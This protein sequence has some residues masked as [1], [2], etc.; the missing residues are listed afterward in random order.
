M[1]FLDN[2]DDSARFGWLGDDAGDP[3]RDQVRLGLTALLTL[4]G[5]PCIYYG[6][7]QSLQGHAPPDVNDSS[8]YVREALWGKPQDPFDPT[9]QMAQLL[10]ALTRIRSSEPALRYGRQYFRQ[11]ADQ[12]STSF[13]VSAAPGGVMA[14]S[15]ILAATEVLIVCN[16]NNKTAWTGDVIIDTSLNPDQ[17]KP[18]AWSSRT[19]SF[20]FPATVSNRPPGTI[21]I[22]GNV[23][24][25]NVRT[26]TV[27]LQPM[28]A[29]IIR[30]TPDPGQTAV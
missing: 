21:T 6:T 29:Q 18:V 10:T 8:G 20:K 16:T 11:T 7:E 9:S 27:A 15:R 22:D 26:I 2:H 17:S 28:E 5:I 14:Y 4:Q 23:T 30:P 12:G 3:W 25:G 24:G 19:G 13:A 1:T